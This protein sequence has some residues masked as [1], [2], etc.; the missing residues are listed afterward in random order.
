MR[1]KNNKLTNLNFE[2]KKPATEDTDTGEDKKLDM[3]ED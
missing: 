1:S 3:W 2:E